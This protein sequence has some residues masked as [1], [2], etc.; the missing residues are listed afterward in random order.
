MLALPNG[1]AQSPSDGG[2]SGGQEKQTGETK[3]IVPAPPYGHTQGPSGGVESELGL[4][5][6]HQLKSNS[7]VMWT[8]LSINQSVGG[9]ELGLDI[10]HQQKR[11]ASTM[12]TTLLTNQSVVGVELGFSNANNKWPGLRQSQMNYGRP[13]TWSVKGLY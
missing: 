11:D 13:V 4:D 2:G 1:H 5:I 8:T 3:H 6:V 9:M 12:R 10:V 7:S